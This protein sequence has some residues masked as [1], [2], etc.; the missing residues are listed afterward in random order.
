MR[1]LGAPVNGR[2]DLIHLGG[3]NPEVAGD[4]IAIQGSTPS[5]DEAI[6][7]IAPDGSDLTLVVTGRARRIGHP[8]GHRSH[9]TSAALTNP[10]D[11]SPET[12]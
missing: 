10:T 12:S 3:I 11:V 7:T 9:T 2:Q 6:Y 8:T 1:C 4:R 5:G